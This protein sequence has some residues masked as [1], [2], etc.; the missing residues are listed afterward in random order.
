[1]TSGHLV[2]TE[3]II[4]MINFGKKV[5]KF[6]VPIFIISILLLI[7][8]AIGYFNTRINYDIL[9][10]LPE[11][12]ETMEGQDILVDEFGTGAFSLFIVEGME[13]K[14]IAGL[15]SQIED[16]DHVSK[17]IWY[18]SILDIS[19]P[20]DML[21]EN[22]V[23]AFNSDDATLMAIIFDETT[24]SDSTME[25]IN[26][27]RDIAG[28]QC[29]LSGMSSVVTDIKYLSEQETPMYI[30]LAA[31]CS[32]I[33][34]GI[35]MD[36][37]LVPV[38]F[39]LSIGMAIIYNLGTNVVMGEISFITQALAAVL[40]L[41]VTMDYSIF[42]WHS[43]KENQVR[44][45]GDKQRAMAHAISNTFTSVIGGSVT[46]VAGFVS[47]MF[48]SFT[49]GLDL[50]IVMVKGVIFGV[51]SCVTVLPSMILIFDRA[52]TKTS[53]KPLLPSFEKTSAFIT[54]HYIVFIT[55][56]LILLFPAIYGNNNTDVY[57]NL[58]DTLPETLESVQ[59]NEELKKNFDMNSAHMILV[60]T[61]I[62]SADVAK[63]SS[64]IDDLDGITAVLGIDSILGGTIP[65]DII[66]DGMAE[67]LKNENWQL[68]LVM[69]EYPIASDDVN[70]QCNEIDN[71]IKSY[72]KDCMLLGEAP[73]TK[74]LIE[75][76]DHDFTVVNSFSIII[77]FIII[78]I[79]FKSISLPAIL[80]AVIEFA[81][82]INMGIPYYTGTVLPFIASIVIGTIQLGATVDYAI[83]M[84]TRYKKERINGND[85]KTA[86]SIAH[87]TS[88]Q[89]VVVS[90]LSF[91]AA[92]IGVGLFSSIDMIS[93]LCLL[94]ARGAIIS[95]IVVL[96]VLPSMLLIFDK[97]ITHTSMDFKNVRMA[98][99]RNKNN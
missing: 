92:T 2:K 90:A 46:T 54:K 24:S 85:R 91:F 48:M 36:S 26:D 53:H 80:V 94:M 29:F 8:S 77:I 84:T 21:P 55:L 18:D 19:I 58:T 71:V 96:T 25:A 98:E 83:L 7:P 49:L 73:C 16:I 51:I 75:I 4:I 56:F 13:E 14:D 61:D 45:D 59:A 11:D 81:I 41:G 10:Y 6:R 95:M 37:F 62:S 68:L 88:M 93:S 78:M 87:K 99:K 64:H 39:L 43:Y 97:V 76:T 27:I 42:L 72:D 66:P 34:L 28:E 22:I 79:L 9:S 44:F 38:L 31:V 86:V 20:M 5:V 69:S 60:P 52:I 70:N 89:S 3:R 82:F 63:M 47:L 32:L 1:M 12:I 33:V 67:A 17:V 65:S 35:T 74:D 50:G 30:V 57:Y 23:E 15:K 40:Q